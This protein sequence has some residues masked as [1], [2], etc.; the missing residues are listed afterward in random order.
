MAWQRSQRR[1][2][3]SR[4]KERRKKEVQPGKAIL[5]GK[6]PFSVF[7]TGLKNPFKLK[8]KTKNPEN[9]IFDYFSINKTI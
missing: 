4:G 3:R 5:G 2:K 8:N 9:K 7:Q 6:V 1:T